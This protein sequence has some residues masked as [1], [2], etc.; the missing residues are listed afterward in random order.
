MVLKAI[1]LFAGA[2]GDS[3]GLELSG[4]DVIGFVEI[5]TIAIKTHQLNFP[6]CHLIGTDITKISD[7]TFKEYHGNIDVIVAGFPCQSFSNAGQKQINN[8]RNFLFREFIR[9]VKLIQPRYIIGENVKGLLTKKLNGVLF[10]DTITTEF[11]DIGYKIKYKVLNCVDYGI[12][13]KRQRLIILGTN[14][15]NDLLFPEKTEQ[16]VNL[17]NIIEFSMENTHKIT[18]FPEGITWIENEKNFELPSNPHPFLKLNF[19]KPPFYKGKIFNSL[20][21][22]EKRDS[23]IHC[24]II[25]VFNPSKTIICTYSFQPR[26]FVPIKNGNGYYLRTLNTSEL[27]Q[28]QT[29]PKEFVFCGNEKE[30]IKQIGNAI[31]PKLINEIIK[32]LIN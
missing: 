24:E 16:I 32:C 21:S 23:P 12:P 19:I 11:N 9:A 15:D 30:Q 2:G 8:P 28:I 25:N 26:L 3:L 22:Y 1:S 17:K 20:F 7:E 4:V 5:D 6:N 18:S 13:Q 27:Q 10:I 14:G 29:F 31:P